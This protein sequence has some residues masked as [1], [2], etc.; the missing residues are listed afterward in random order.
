MRHFF[1]KIPK[2]LLHLNPQDQF[3]IFNLFIKI[4]FI[5]FLS[6]KNRGVRGAHTAI[7]F[8]LFKKPY[9]QNKCA[10]FCLFFA[11]FLL[12]SAKGGTLTFSQH[13]KQFY[14]LSAFLRPAQVPFNLRMALTRRWREKYFKASVILQLAIV[15]AC[16]VLCLPLC[17]CCF[18]CFPTASQMLYFAF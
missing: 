18:G 7:L 13:S 5:S 4:G 16:C 6:F 9:Q 10:H 8:I 14:S 12:K 17:C 11:S 1:F 15:Y 3:L 2:I